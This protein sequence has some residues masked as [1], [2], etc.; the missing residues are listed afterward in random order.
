MSANVPENKLVE[1]LFPD[2][3]IRDVLNEN[4]GMQA[5]E[6][7]DSMY[8]DAIRDGR[9]GDAIW[10]RY[11]ISGNVENGIPNAS[12]TLF[13]NVP[14]AQRSKSQ[15]ERHSNLL[16][17]LIG[18]RAKRASVY[19]M[20]VSRI[21]SEARYPLCKKRVRARELK[22]RREVGLFATISLVSL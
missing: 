20:S 7:W 17:N 9:F 3:S 21:V 13:Q 18:S 12:P 8:V 22:A 15:R 4:A 19:N 11:H 2:L 6:P 14:I 5:V 1:Q 10:A 16:I